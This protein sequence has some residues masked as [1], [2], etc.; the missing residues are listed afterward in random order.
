MTPAVDPLPVV[1]G[2]AGAQAA[3]RL[4]PGGAASGHEQP[5]GVRRGE[6]LLLLWSTA[7]LG[8]A[9][10]LTGAAAW[11]MVGDGNHLPTWILLQGVITTAGAL[12]GFARPGSWGAITSILA[13]PAAGSLVLAAL[14]TFAGPAV[15]RTTATFGLLLGLWTG[16]WAVLAT[17]A[18]A[19]DRRRRRLDPRR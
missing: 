13:G 18:R 11:A 4:D 16:V 10:I 5:P 8:L 6:R 15:G 2:R 12:V 7:A 17:V 19:I 9:L 1:P 14:L 3:V